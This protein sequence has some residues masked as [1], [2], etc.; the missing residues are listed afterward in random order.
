MN[1]TTD[2]PLPAGPWHV[3]VHP[4]IPLWL[5]I[6]G[7]IIAVGLIVFLYFAQRG[8]APAWAIVPLT[9]LRVAL[10][11]L[12]GFILLQPSFQWI[13]TQHMPGTLWLLLDRSKSMSFTDPQ[14]LPEERL[15]WACS[16][17]YIPDS[18]WSDEFDRD[19]AQ[20][21]ILR[22]LLQQQQDAVQNIPLAADNASRQKQIDSAVNALTQ[23]RQKLGDL[24]DEL[25]GRQGA[26]MVNND[27]ASLDQDT[28]ALIDA[29]RQ[30]GGAG[31]LSFSALLA[32]VD[33][34]MRDL[35][36]AAEAADQQFLSVHQSDPVVVDALNRV[37]AMS[38]SQLAL[39][40]LQNS[41][42]QSLASVIAQNRVQVVSFAG[43]AT[44]FPIPNN[45]NANEILSS[46]L[47]ANGDSTNIASAFSTVAQAQTT[48]EPARVI[49]ISDGRQN[50][51]DDPEPIARLLA[52]DGI[53]T[54]TICIGSDRSPP[55][56]Q[57]DAVDAPQWVYKDQTV[58]A[59]VAI[60][61]QELMGRPIT[62]QL[63]RDD[64]PIDRQVTFSDSDDDV[65]SV[66]FS[67]NPGD[68]GVYHY[69]V[70]VEPPQGV[71]DQE[72][73]EREFMVAVRRDKLQ[74]LLVENQPRWEYQY[75][76][77]YLSRNSRIH[78]QAVLEN[79]APVQGVQLPAPVQASPDNPSY[80]AQVLPQGNA[81][82]G[83]YDLIILGDVGPDSINDADQQAIVYAVAQ[84]GAALVLLSGQNAMPQAYNAQPLSDLIPVRLDQ[85]WPP[86]ILE[87]QDDQGF[88]PAIT[89]EGAASDL[90][91]FGANSTQNE[92]L[93]A[94]MSRWYSHS[95]YT[96]ARDNANVI[97]SLGGGN[98]P[99]QQAAGDEENIQEDK[100]QALLTEMNVGAGR[101]LYLAS[102]ELWRL[103]YV[104]GENVFDDFWAQVV[105][106]CSGN[107][108]PA[109]GK[110]VR[111]GTDKDTYTYGDP[112][113]VAA[114]VLGDN[115]LPLSGLTFQVT[116]TPSGAA[117]IETQATS[118]PMLAS[119]SGPGFYSGTLSGLPPGHYSIRLQG[120]G[121][122]QRLRAD[123]TAA[124]QQL[125]IQINPQPDLESLDPSSDPADMLRL[126]SA[127]GG[128]MM[129]GAFAN[130]LASLMPP[131]ER[132]L[133][134]PQETGFFVNMNSEFT[135]L[136]H[137][138][139]LA[140][141]VFLI[142]AEWAIRKIAGMV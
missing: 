131:L 140:I 1:Q 5:I 49:L 114:R 102:D 30:S 34:A 50:V 18:L 120:G 59:T 72:P 78:L 42:K 84:K 113:H 139:F 23:W 53:D 71:A 74:V 81:G 2:N 105:R 136:L 26:R 76:I 8:S 117:T 65:K 63:L 39:E 20:L 86:D 4:A 130:Q 129:P 35:N 25:S 85:A 58:N 92:A 48:P 109:G 21:N 46:A 107:D 67:D 40:M 29:I 93:W 61:M 134:I 24:T 128:L 133:D 66:Q 99:D 132:T 116:A 15:R 3:V 80:M 112:V 45:A 91:Q 19:L 115:L 56:V 106:W 16:L 73:I 33:G 137:I 64:K 122:D 52:A 28:G 98:S 87:Q 12:L 79:P 94:G 7:M 119:N 69:E 60:H 44:S 68:V 111:F 77:N 11:L 6:F 142:T 104:A 100:S 32:G 31:L 43:G 126:A 55:S 90:A 124:A 37:S 22:Q 125:T 127:G 83:A 41:Q 47:S 118:A 54:F 95:A 135:H 57:I 36:D 88:V 141:F 108:L 89:V 121:V 70:R 82:W 9:L 14:A 96:T 62:V 138:L 75:L 27:L 38:R 101:V 97:W 103:R 51:G 123:P 110:F 13:N 10:I 17:G